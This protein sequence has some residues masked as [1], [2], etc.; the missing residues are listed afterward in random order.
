MLQL[1]HG[2]QWGAALQQR[3][4]GFSGSVAQWVETEGDVVKDTE[5]ELAGLVVLQDKT[6]F[7]K[8]YRYKSSLRRLLFPFGS[9]RPLAAWRVGQQMADAG[10]PVAAPLACLRA[11]EGIILLSEALP[12]SNNFAELWPQ[13]AASEQQA[14][15]LAAA[16]AL[17]ALH[18]AGFAHGD[19]KW[20]NFVFSAECCYLVDLD[21]A[22]AT[23]TGSASQARD[24]AR[25]TVSAEESQV[26]PALYAVFLD[27]YV[28][29]SAWQRERLTAQLRGQLKKI[30]RRHR[31]SYGIDVPPLV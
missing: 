21:A 8:L 26:A 2:E 27:A 11:D 1:V 18:Q 16:R 23:Q 30:R 3:C 5:H 22:R 20:P 13:C 10:L 6:C 28:Q 19:C 7:F 25:F 31:A 29:A 4:A 15:L 17:A 24:V 14:H 9:R 12:S